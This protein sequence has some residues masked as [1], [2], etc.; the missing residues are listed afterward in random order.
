MASV[1]STGILDR[2]ELDEKFSAGAN[3]FLE[4][5]VLFSGRFSRDV[6]ATLSASFYPF[7]FRVLWLLVLGFLGR[8]CLLSSA[9]VIGRP[10][11]R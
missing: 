8:L 11:T 10:I 3:R 9:N 4:E 1:D 2:P 6:F 7:R 5:E